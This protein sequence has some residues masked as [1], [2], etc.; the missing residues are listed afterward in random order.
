V[1]DTTGYADTNTIVIRPSHPSEGEERRTIT[2]TPTEHVITVTAALA[3]AHGVGEVVGE[4]ATPTAVLTI[5]LPD[6]TTTAPSVTSSGGVHTATL[7]LTQAGRHEVEWS[8]TGNG[9]GELEYSFEV[10]SNLIT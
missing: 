8:G 2:G 3:F 9:A 10:L 7:A 6:G 1:G 4:L 5:E